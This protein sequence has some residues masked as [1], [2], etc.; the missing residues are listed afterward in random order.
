MIISESMA[1]ALAHL[2]MIYQTASGD[3]SPR[4]GELEKRKA[5]LVS[6][7]H[8]GQCVATDE[9]RQVANLIHSTVNSLPESDNSLPANID[10]LTIT[11]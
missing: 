1:T 8:S 3:Y 9:D 6:F 4:K 7:I 2:E 11:A 10:D 5:A